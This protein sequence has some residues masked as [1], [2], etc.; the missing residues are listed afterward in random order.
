MKLSNG[1]FEDAPTKLSLFI[2]SRLDSNDSSWIDWNMSAVEIE[3]FINAFDDPYK[4]LTL[5][6][7]KK[8]RLKKSNYIVKKLI[9]TLTRV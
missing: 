3:R 1:K 4:S 5:I 6:N 8:V 7:N 2:L 9:L